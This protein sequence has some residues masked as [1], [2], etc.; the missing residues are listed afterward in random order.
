MPQSTEEYTPTQADI[1]AGAPAASWTSEM[2]MPVG[3]YYSNDA[4]GLAKARA[5]LAA[6]GGAPEIVSLLDAGRLDMT[7][8]TNALYNLRWSTTNAKNY[9]VLD[10]ILYRTNLASGAIQNL[11]FNKFPRQN[12]PATIQAIA[13]YAP[14]VALAAISGGS[15]L[16]GLVG[17]SLGGAALGEA[18][19]I[20]AQLGSQVLGGALVGAGTGAIG[21][22]IQGG[23]I[24]QGALYGGLSGGIAPGVSYGVNYLLPDLSSAVRSGLSSGLTS[25]GV[26]YARYG[27]LTQALE[28]GAVSGV[29]S[30]LGSELFPGSD[31]GRTLTTGL[32]SAALGRLL[33][34]G[35]GGGQ[36][37]TTGTPSVRPTAAPGS[38]PI[39]TA[40]AIQAAQPGTTSQYAPGSPILGA[41]ESD[42]TSKRSGWNIASLR[43]QRP[44]E[45]LS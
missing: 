8:L 12:L 36:G 10:S 9:P 6:W 3:S 35:G 29:A 38:A 42:T 32:T 43:T 15:A 33:S 23:D 18:L 40:Q 4:A 19:G 25:A 30:Y 1:E 16:P 27:N 22:A 34:G 21:S 20:G 14:A 11:D 2:S 28:R 41:G 24:G 26:D 17:Q 31:L 44:E 7:N 5:D 37:Y 39:Q 45:G 13:Q